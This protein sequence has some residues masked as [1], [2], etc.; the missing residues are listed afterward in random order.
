METPS[1]AEKHSQDLHPEAEA[2]YRR[3]F[4]RFVFL[5]VVC[6]LVPLLLVGWGINIHYTRFAKSRTVHSFQTQMAHHR[7]I[8][9]LFLKECTSKLHI[10]A[11]THTRAHL[12]QTLNLDAVFEAMNQA[13][14]SFTD[15]GVID[16]SGNHLAYVGPFDLLSKN[17]A[18]ALWFKEVMDKGVYISDMF[19][20]FRQVP[21]FIIAVRRSEKNA[22]WVLRATIDT[23]VFRALVENVR[24]GRSGEVMLLNGDGIFQTSTRF[25]GKIMKK[26]PFSIPSPQVGVKIDIVDENFNGGDRPAPRQI[27]ARTWLSQPRWLLMLRQDYAEAL[28]EANHANRLTLVFLHISAIII[29]IVTVLITRHMIGVVRKKDQAAVLL[30]KQFMQSS[31]LAS[32]G[33]L[34]AGVA[35]EI[36]NPLAII[37]TEKQILM[38]MAEPGE[39]LG[40]KFERQ[41]LDSM[42]Q[43]Q[44][45][46]QRCKRITQNLLR[47]SRRTRSII[48]TVDLNAFISELVELMEREARSGGIRIFMDLDE[49][50]PE[51]KSDPSQ[52]QQVFLN[53]LTNAMDAHDGMPYGSVR[54][55]TRSSNGGSGVHLLFADTGAGIK[56]GDLERI[57]DPFFTTKQV[58]KGTGLGLSVCYSIIRRLGGEI[59]VRSTPGEGAEFRLRLPVTP[60]P[61]LEKDVAGN[62]AEV[63]LN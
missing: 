60:P 7:K 37:L 33:E 22:T 49:S 36:N 30:N 46:I 58:G 39:P 32:I 51:I 43:I 63:V 25:S 8:V 40:P 20:G 5:T 45:Q 35:H 21:H 27:V 19:M 15:L 62:G 55:T 48:E 9:E 24:I 56:A 10:I 16:D 42:S 26:A 53:L 50:L 23:E 14:G 13:D 54:I 52:L 6:S 44:V 41:F 57:F 28:D 18:S 1:G 4:W 12:S 2:H 17:Y 47:Y 3:L 38:D 34:S 11:Q 61:E 59:S 29:L 31:K